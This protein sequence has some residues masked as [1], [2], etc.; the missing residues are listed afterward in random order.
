GVPVAR[1]PDLPPADVIAWDRHVRSM[2]ELG[3][4]GVAAA[5]VLAHLHQP[6]PKGPARE[7]IF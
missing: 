5:E 3:R 1:P 2:Q 7:S 6:A 4:R